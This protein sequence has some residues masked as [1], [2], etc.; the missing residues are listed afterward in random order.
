MN[1]W[2]A[3]CLNWFHDRKCHINWA[4]ITI[5]TVSQWSELYS[6]FFPCK[7]EWVFSIALWVS[8]TQQQRPWRDPKQQQQQR[9]RHHVSPGRLVE[10]EQHDQGGQWLHL[11]GPQAEAG[12]LPGARDHGQLDGGRPLRAQRVQHLHTAQHQLGRAR[13]H[14][15]LEHRPQEREHPIRETGEHLPGKKLKT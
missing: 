9:G 5:R 2:S 3:R 4:T 10:P 12:R 11:P 1:I 7:W 8:M 6:V 13:G 14:R 15:G